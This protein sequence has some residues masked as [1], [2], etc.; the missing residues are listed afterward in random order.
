[1][2]LQTR[3]YILRRVALSVALLASVLGGLLLGTPMGTPPQQVAN[4]APAA[5]ASSSTTTYND[6]FL[7]FTGGDNVACAARNGALLCWQGNG[8]PIT[9]TTMTSGVTAVALS[10]TGPH[11]AIRNGAVLCWNGGFSSNWATTNTPGIVPSLTSAVVAVDVSYRHACALRSGA[12]LCWG[13]NESGQLGNGT[14]AHSSVPITATG[15][16]SGVSAISVGG[17]TN[18]GISC[19]IK[20]NQLYCWG[21]GYGTTPQLITGMSGVTNVEVGPGPTI[22]AIRNGAA[23]CL[24][25][26]GTGLTNPISALSSGVTSIAVNGSPN[27]WG[28][29]TACAVRN[30]AVFCWGGDYGTSYTSP[31]AM[32]APLNSGVLAVSSYDCCLASWENHVL[33][34]RNNGCLYRWL[35]GGSPTLVSCGWDL[36]TPPIGPFSKTAPVSGTVGLPITVT[37][38]WSAPV[39]GT[40]HHYRYCL[41]TT[42]GCT[43]STQVPST[44]TSVTVSGLT[45]GA[46]YHWQVRACAIDGCGSFTDANSGTHWTFTVKPLPSQSGFNKSAPTNGASGVSTAPTLSWNPSSGAVYYQVC[47]D[48]NL[49]G[50]CNGTW[51]NV[52]GT[53]QALSGL[54]PGATYE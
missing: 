37:L 38:Q 1:M 18:E 14:T 17:G 4:A 9:V 5:L 28:S 10:W 13:N 45:P 47:Y 16:E 50:A 21:F 29:T 33:A 3:L 20:N 7:P 49:N 24:S 19:A 15:M 54:A 46:T 36:P 53:S 35:P 41:A 39:T 8:T 6:G 30:G 26:L 23:S 22:C 52:N 34:L 31:A 27:A 43:P 40:V 48:T 51:Q 2:Y 44:T 25:P 32:P 11:C 12:V 42:T